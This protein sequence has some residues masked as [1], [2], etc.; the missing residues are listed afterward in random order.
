VQLSSS[1]VVAPGNQSFVTDETTPKAILVADKAMT[2]ESLNETYKLLDLSIN[3]YTP[4]ASN[5]L[6]GMVMTQAVRI[7]PATLQRTLLKRSE[8]PTPMIAEL[9]TCEVLTGRPNSEAPMIT[10]AEVNW[11]EKLCSGRIL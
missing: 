6:A 7:S 9:T 8:A 4:A 3:Q 1:T 11:V 5:A 2:T 10:N